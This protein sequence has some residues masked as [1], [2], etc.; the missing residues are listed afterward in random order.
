MKNYTD[1]ILILATGCLLGFAFGAFLHSFAKDKTH[2]QECMMKKIYPTVFLRCLEE[3]EKEEDDKWASF[4]LTLRPDSLWRDGVI[5][6]TRAIRFSTVKK[7]TRCEVTVGM[8]G[9][10]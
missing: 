7:L 8:E 5:T 3:G 10:E 4:I 9:L 1:Y 2:T 6:D